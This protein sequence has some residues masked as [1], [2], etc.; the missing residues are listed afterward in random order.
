MPDYNSQI[1]Y[2]KQ[3]DYNFGQITTSSILIPAQF[4]QQIDKE[5]QTAGVGSQNP[6]VLKVLDN[7]N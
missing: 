2:N 1:N 4:M 6:Y 7:D 5:T 3:S